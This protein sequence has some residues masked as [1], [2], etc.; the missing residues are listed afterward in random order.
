M[1][2]YWKG[3]GITQMLSQ[4]SEGYRT[5]GPHDPTAPVGYPCAHSAGGH[6][7]AG[8]DRGYLVKQ[9]MATTSS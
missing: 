1:A 5:R 9:L 8:V 4:G 6:S 2:A 3:F 7:S